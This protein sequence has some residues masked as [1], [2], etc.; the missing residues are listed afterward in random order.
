MGKT[1]AVDG[2]TILDPKAVAWPCG[3]IAKSIFTDSY[4]LA[5]AAG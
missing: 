2:V 1:V 3:L 4:T 5:T